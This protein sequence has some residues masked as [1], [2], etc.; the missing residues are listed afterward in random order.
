MFVDEL[1]DVTSLEKIDDWVGYMEE[2]IRLLRRP[3]VNGINDPN[4]QW[5]DAK[6]VNFSYT[7]YNY[8]ILSDS[9]PALGL[10]NTNVELNAIFYAEIKTFVR[11]ATL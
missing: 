6:R 11:I 9:R 7:I 8:F 2:S 1:L 10:R 5:V 3:C 4:Y